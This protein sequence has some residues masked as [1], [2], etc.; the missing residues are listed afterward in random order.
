MAMTAHVVYRALDPDRPATTSPIVVEEIMRGA[1]GFDGLIMSDDVSMN[2]LSGPFESARETIFDAGLDIALHCNGDLDEARAVAS[3]TPWLAGES[4]RRAE[5]AL[6]ATR[7]PE[8][9]DLKEARAE[10]AAISA[11]LGVVRGA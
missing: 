2:A 5:A 7:P 6:A 10:L 3:V 9:L 4:A 1:I 8:P 11:V